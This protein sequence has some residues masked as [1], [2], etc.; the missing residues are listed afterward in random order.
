MVFFGNR[1]VWK[2]SVEAAP[3]G[4][5][6]EPEGNDDVDDG[7]K[8]DPE[9]SGRDLEAAQADTAAAEAEDAAAAAA[10]ARQADDLDVSGNADQAPSTSPTPSGSGSGIS[11]IP[12][13]GDVLKKIKE[14]GIYKVAQEDFGFGPIMSVFVS[15]MYYL[16]K[17]QLFDLDTSEADEA[18][19]ALEAA[20]KTLQQQYQV[21]VD[22]LIKG[23]KL[24]AGIKVS[25]TDS[26]SI[27]Q[28]FGIKSVGELKTYLNGKDV[29]QVPVGTS[30]LDYL[31]KLDDTQ[32]TS[33]PAAPVAVADVDADSDS[34]DAVV[35]PAEAA[36]PEPEGPFK[37]SPKE[38]VDF[39]HGDS[40]FFMLPSG[41]KVTLGRYEIAING[42][43]FKIFV[44]KGI[45]N[46]PLQFDK[47][48][49][50]TNGGYN[51]AMSSAVDVWGVSEEAKKANVDM[52]SDE[53][54]DF[55]S[56]L[57]AQE[58]QSKFAK[59]TQNKDGEDVKLV[60]EAV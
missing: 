34:A 59:T 56:Y 3:S 44:D 47:L 30:L 28:V 15:V 35:V 22:A 12:G 21:S 39:S 31:D 10:I 53:I 6:V 51:L 17:D 54:V 43:K 8:V 18:Q 19:R 16:Y 29:I 23:D 45:K 11:E 60:F 55:L 27:K 14:K 5:E 2:D 20:R 49:P 1:L 38:A 4:A 24:P 41:D 7:T 52:T 32:A 40:A 50:L 36:A 26:A 33:P 42:K 37:H 13:M 25:E 48:S 57:A 46:I 58:G 9:K